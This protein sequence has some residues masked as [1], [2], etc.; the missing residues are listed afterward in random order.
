M[1]VVA[2]ANQKGGVAKTTTALHLAAGLVERDFRVLLID[3]DPQANA[4]ESLSF[5]SSDVHTRGVVELLEQTQPVAAIRRTLRTGFD[6]IPSHIRTAR[7]E[8]ALNSP[9]DIYRLQEALS[10]VADDYDFAVI[11]CPPSLGRLTTNA[12][13]AA[14]SV[15]VPVRPAPYGLSAVSDF[16]D[17]LTLVRQR[18][19]EKLRLLGILLTL[20]DVRTRMA[21]DVADVLVADH[22]D[23]VF[24][25]RIR[26][27]VRLDE[28]ASAQTSIFDFAPSSTGAQDYNAF[29]EEVLERVKR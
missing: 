29:V 20:Y 26:M 2:I 25:T 24:G 14:N 15:I 5:D 12:L 16:F 23:A 1:H 17:T 22:G 8:P 3:L 7:L 27:S 11:D 6:L 10:P 9:F 21:S 28:A 19:N 18:L 4:T 13:V